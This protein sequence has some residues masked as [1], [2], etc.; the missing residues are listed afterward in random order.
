MALP[1][2]KLSAEEEAQLTQ[3]IEMFEVI[4]QG[5]PQDYQSLEILKEAYVK[6]GKEDDL[7]R[8]SKRVAEAYVL[9]GQLSSAILEYESL[10]QHKPDDQEVQNSLRE[11]EARAQDLNT[12]PASDDTIIETAPPGRRVASCIDDGAKGMKKL[13]VDGKVISAQDF[14]LCWVPPDYNAPPGTITVPFIQNLVDKGILPIER[15]LKTLVEKTRLGF[16][17]IGRYDC[18]VD[19]SRSVDAELCR[20]WCIL[21]FDRMSKTILVATAN[22]FNQQAMMEL[23]QAK[24]GQRIQLYLAP[25]FDLMKA[26]RN[27]FR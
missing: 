6:L 3:T 8:T 26:I 18:D 19:V 20:R 5:Q 23:E 16:I 10:L 4:T 22:P 14:D 9:M 27:S 25:P 21:P 15:A 1:L 17:P 13:F 7:I 2:V 12:A 24:P 11:L